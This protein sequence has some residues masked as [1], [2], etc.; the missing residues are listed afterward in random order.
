V[1]E[2]RRFHIHINASHLIARQ[3]PTV[4]GSDVRPNQITKIL[5]HGCPKLRNTLRWL[6][7]E[8]LPEIK[9]QF[10]I[11]DSTISRI[12]T[13]YLGVYSSLDNLVALKEACLGA[14]GLFLTPA[15]QPILP[16]NV[17]RTAKAPLRHPPAQHQLP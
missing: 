8:H 12:R 9:F 1:H 3:W 15:D 10:P 6:T 14:N 7:L 4:I 16:H 5:N 11:V 13:N 2:S 17:A